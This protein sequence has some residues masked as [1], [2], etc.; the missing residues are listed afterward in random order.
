[1]K[2]PTLSLQGKTAVVTGC[3]QGLGHGL[4][5]AVAAAGANVVLVDRNTSHLEALSSEIKSMGLGTLI[6]ATDITREDSVI[7]MVQSVLNTFDSIEI[8]VNNAGI[9]H[10]VAAVETTFDQWQQTI[11]VNLTG[12]FLCGREIGK[13]MIRQKKGKIVNIASIN[14]AVARP[15]LSAYGASKSAVTQLT[16]CWALEW[17]THNINVN[18]VAPSFVMTEMTRDLFAD[19]DVRKQLL[20]RVPLGRIGTVEDI[21]AAVLFLACEASNYI[22]GHTLFVDGGWVIQ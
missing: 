1:M 22:T 2:L 8:L 14:S 13:A 4:A 7:E 10:R 17:A 15:N 5:L 16:R 11:D 6:C 12:V 18:A 19:P 3:N 20:E 21:A 9:A